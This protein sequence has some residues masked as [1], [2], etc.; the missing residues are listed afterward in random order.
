MYNSRF[1][2]IE[3]VMSGRSSNFA[4]TA[5]EQDIS[6]SSPE[7]DNNESDRGCYIIVDVMLET[8]VPC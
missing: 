5:P 4:I 8:N 3:S 1:N 6:L 2:S 7:K